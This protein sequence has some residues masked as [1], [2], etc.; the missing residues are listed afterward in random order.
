MHAEICERLIELSDNKT[1]AHVVRWIHR[2]SDIARD[3]ESTEALWLYLRLSTGD[4]SQLMAS[5][6][7][8]GL[9]RSRSK[10]A[11]HIEQRKALRVLGRHFPEIAAQI[12]ALENLRK[13]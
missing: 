2:M 13:A 8:R 9:E 1:R 6:S 5:L 10:Q 11:E 3:D 12:E 7:Q 4:L